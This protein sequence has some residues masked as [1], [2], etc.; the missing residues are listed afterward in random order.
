MGREASRETFWK[1]GNPDQIRG[2]HLRRCGEQHP[3]KLK[4]IFGLTLREK[5][6]WAIKGRRALGNSQGD[7]GSSIH[8]NSEIN[9]KS[10]INLNPGTNLTPH[11]S[12]CIQPGKRA[13]VWWPRKAAGYVREPHSLRQKHRHAPWSGTW[14]SSKTGAQTLSSPSCWFVYCLG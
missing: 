4:T 10:E 14:L 11:G 9:L 5:G 13:A 6:R 7:G 1:M 2:I 12:T 8:E 3:G